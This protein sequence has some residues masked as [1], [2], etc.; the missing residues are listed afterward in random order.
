MDV[1]PSWA[2]AMQST[3]VGTQN[4]IKVEVKALAHEIKGCSARIEI[5]ETKQV[6]MERRL[7]KLENAS[8]TSTY[9][10]STVGSSE[11]FQP[12][13]IEIKG[14]CKFHQTR[15]L[16]VTR[17]K[18]T[19]LMKS[20]MLILPEE[21]KGHVGDFTLRAAKNYSIK[22]PIQPNFLR[23]I[24]NT[25]RDQLQTNEAKQSIGASLFI[26]FERPDD[27]KLQY[28]MT[29]KVETFVAD[30]MDGAANV[31]TFWH[32]AFEIHLEEDLIEP[33]NDTTT[34]TATLVA[35]VGLFG[36]VTWNL[37]GLKKI[38]I[39]SETE[40]TQKLQAFKRGR[41]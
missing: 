41:K 28:S 25:W 13:Y 1:A 18:A 36:T 5:L 17:P 24:S 11:N 39:R 8:P 14:W 38:Q 10:P 6:A 33:N 19:E 30:N 34:K 4:E 22:V 20:L 21:L 12:T 15:E 16:G 7:L 37:A 40:A 9:A 27:V 23:E 2:V 26:T 35:T 29:G 32:L 31:R 3:L